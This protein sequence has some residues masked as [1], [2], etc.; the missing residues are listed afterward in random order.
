MKSLQNYLITESSRHIITCAT[1]SEAAEQACDEAEKKRRSHHGGMCIEYYGSDY[2]KVADVFYK[3]YSV[4]C[5]I[6][7]NDKTMAI[8]CT[9]EMEK[10]LCY[11]DEKSEETFSDMG[12]N[13]EDFGW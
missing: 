10:D 2:D 5:Y 12:L 3:W 1:Y 8:P 6:A 13:Y 11:S 4:N 9:D 7:K